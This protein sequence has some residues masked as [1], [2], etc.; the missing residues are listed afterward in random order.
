MS[1]IPPLPHD[2]AYKYLFSSAYV[3]HQFLT[4]FVDEPWSREL[5]LEDVEPVD[6]SFVS[7]QLRKR[8]SDVIYR[9]RLRDRE[10]YL[11]ILIEFQS[12]VDKSIPLRMLLYIL[13]LYDELYRNSLSGL[14]PAIFPIMLYNGPERWTVP[15]NIRDLIE[16]VIAPRYLPS[17]EYY[18]IIEQ[19]IPE[20]KLRRIKGLISAMIYLE[21]RRDHDLLSE[22][23]DVVVDLLSDEAAEPLRIRSSDF[24][25]SCVRAIVLRIKRMH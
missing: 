7:D 23:V 2:G 6:R 14:L 9:V 8:E 22:A 18:L 17:L 24:D 15:T 20:E 25:P 21:Q 3:V 10:I 11:Y 16:P 4:R 13:Q 19:E 12:T 1:I 5:R